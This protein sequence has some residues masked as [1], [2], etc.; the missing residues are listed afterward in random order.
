ML[1]ELNRRLLAIGN[2]GDQNDVETHWP[3]ILSSD[4]A[5]EAQTL[6]AHQ[7][8]GVV[9]TETLQRK[10]GYDPETEAPKIAAEKAADTAQQT[11]L[12]KAQP[13]PPQP[14]AEQGASNG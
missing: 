4:P 5:G 3:E 12:L 13:P 11:A 10:L 14:P 6:A 8:M 1:A 7:R 2:F 9:S